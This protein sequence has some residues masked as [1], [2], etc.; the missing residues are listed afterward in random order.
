MPN[1]ILSQLKALHCHGM[2][3]AWSECTAESS[4]LAAETLLQRLIDAEIAERQARSLSYQLSICQEI[5]WSF[6]RGN[7]VIPLAMK[8]IS[9]N[10]HPPQ[11]C[12]RHLFTFFINVFIQPCRNFQALLC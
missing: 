3:A 6:L 9:V 7:L 8:C 12:I 10:I 4:P 11:F 2:A 5:S 1:D